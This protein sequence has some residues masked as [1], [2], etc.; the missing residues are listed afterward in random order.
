MAI[1]TWGSLEKSASDGEKIEDMV[2]RK[3]NEHDADPTAHLSSGGSL[4]NHKEE[5]TIDHP[6]G[7]IPFD[8]RDAGNMV[9]KDFFHS[10]SSNYDPEGHV[11]SGSGILSVWTFHEVDGYSK[12]DVP[13]PLFQRSTWPSKELVVQFLAQF[14]W[15]STNDKISFVWGGIAPDV[16]NGF[17]LK[18]LNGNLYAVLYFGGAEVISAPLAYTKTHWATFR[19]HVVP[20]DGVARFYMNGEVVATLA[21]GATQE[22]D[23]ADL[24]IVTEAGVSDY[25]Y[26]FMSMLDVGFSDDLII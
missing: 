7:S 11:G 13:M 16:E 1:T 25:A 14:N 17:G 26:A 21:L 12:A 24:F 19:I 6:A 5:T 15:N 10:A 20:F 8:K 22:S 4:A 23:F 9:Y 3:I 18:V 2:D